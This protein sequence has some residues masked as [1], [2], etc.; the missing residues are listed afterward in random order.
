M[1]VHIDANAIIEWEKG[2][3]DL[4]AWIADHHPT[5]TLKF[6]AAAWQELVYGAFAWEPARAQKRWRFLNLLRLSVCPYARRQAERAARIAAHLK[7]MP[8]GFA[9]C[10]VAASAIEDDATLLSFNHEHFSRVPGLR[11]AKV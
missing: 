1:N 10:Q 7:G 11:L 9:D 3:F 6:S 4:P 8:I 2:K 5:D